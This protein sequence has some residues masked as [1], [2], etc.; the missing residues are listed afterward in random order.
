MAIS[1]KIGDHV[2][3]VAGAC[4]HFGTIDSFRDPVLALVR[5]KTDGHRLIQVELGRLS[6]AD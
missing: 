3:F 2:K 4:W 6:L 5:P 1:L